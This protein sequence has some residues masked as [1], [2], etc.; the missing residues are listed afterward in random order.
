LAETT[1]N[2]AWTDLKAEAGGYLG[3]GRTAAN[4]D[5]NKTEE[6]TRLMQSALRKFYFQAAVDPREPAYGWTFLKPVADIQLATGVATAPLPDD[7]GGFEGTATVRLGDGLAGGYWPLQQ[8]HDEQLRV[9]YAAAPT[10]NGRTVY[11]SEKQVKGVSTLGSNRSDLYVYPLPDNPYIVSVA[12]FILPNYVT[13]AAP[14]PY[15]GA[16]H[17]ETMKAAVR[18]AAELYLDNRVGPEDANY[19]QCLT[20]SITYDRRHQPKSLGVNTDPSD[21]MMQRRTGGMWPDGLWHPLG[22]GALGTAVY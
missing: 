5:S 3:W 10:I 6:I 19:R 20:S 11:Y 2:L 18:A 4:W 21:W 14:Y 13:T 16:A 1:L 9:L 17:A 22:I 12:Y 7:F 15:G 8:R